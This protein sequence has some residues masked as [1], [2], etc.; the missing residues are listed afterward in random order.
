MPKDGFFECVVFLLF[1]TI[2]HFFSRRQIKRI[3]NPNNRAS[4][5]LKEMFKKFGFFG[6]M[7]VPYFLFFIIQTVFAITF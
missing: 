3:D 1:I 7:V 5:D 4:E 6:S 2:M